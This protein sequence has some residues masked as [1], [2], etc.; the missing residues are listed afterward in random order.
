MSDQILPRYLFIPMEI[1]WNANLQNLDGKVYGIIYWY[2]K[3]SK[4]KCIASNRQIAD[5][6]TGPYDKAKKVNHTSVANSIGRLAKEGFVKV[7]LE[8]SQRTEIIPL[9]TEVTEPF[10]YPSST[11]EG[12][13]ISPTHPSLN[14]ETFEPNQTLTHHLQMK[15]NESSNIDPSSTDDAPLHL[16]MNPPSSTD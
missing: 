1:E 15:G 6:I 12:S 10:N 9:F 2:S 14:D 5:A 4:K 13:A 8:H 3:M 16:V 11:D 7:V